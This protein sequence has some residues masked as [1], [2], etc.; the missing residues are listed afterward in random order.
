MLNNLKISHKGLLLVAIPLLFEIL[1]FV[2]VL[3]FLAQ[4]ESMRLEELKSKALIEEANGISISLYDIGNVMMSAWMKKDKTGVISAFQEKNADISNRF[5]KL[6]KLSADSKH[7]RQRVEKIFKFSER[8]N[9]MITDMAMKDITSTKPVGTRF[10]YI[11]MTNDSYGPLLREIRE[12]TVSERKNLDAKIKEAHQFNEYAKLSLS[13]AVLLSIF[14]TAVLAKFFSTS[15]SHRLNV[16]VRNVD[17]FKD[18]EEL[19]PLLAG[20]DEISLVDDAFHSMVADL[21]LAE[22]KKQEFL[23]MISHDMRAP[24]TALQGTLAVATTGRYGEVNEYGVERLANAERNVG[25]LISLI[26]DLLDLE[27]MESDTIVLEFEEVNIAE[28][29]GSAIDSLLPVSDK[30][31]IEVIN[32]VK[33]RVLKID[34][35]RIEQVLINLLSNAIKFSPEG[36]QVT[37]SGAIEDGQME[38]RV[39]DQGRGIPSS[40]LDSIFERF[41]QV[42]REDGDKGR[43][44][45]LGLA[46]CKHLIEAHSGE[47]GVES[48]IGEGSTFWIRIPL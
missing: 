6:R 18:K 28:I 40:E 2:L 32:K 34:S 31:D 13:I 35:R 20:D 21:N 24:L 43:G 4:A 47:I 3:F 12:L 7:Q 41:N 27:R 26:N 17:K 25:R 37:V 19:E 15:I 11:R 9:R 10:D 1:F 16:L 42:E 5:R 44:Y 36:S 46:I 29:V 14:V 23:S 38:I 48:Q 39:Q 45:G 30:K 33:S 8:M 22:E